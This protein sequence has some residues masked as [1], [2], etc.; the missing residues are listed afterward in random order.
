MSAALAVRCGCQHRL[1]LRVQ[2]E[3]LQKLR[4]LIAATS[5]PPTGDE[6]LLSYRC[7]DCKQIIELRLGDLGITEGAA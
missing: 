5:A 4:A 2:P 1:P 3:G 6:A 7:P